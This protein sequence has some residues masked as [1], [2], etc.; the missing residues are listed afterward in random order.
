MIDKN[1]QIQLIAV[2]S[3]SSTLSL[4]SQLQTDDFIAIWIP[5]YS[6]QIKANN[7]TESH[8]YLTHSV[9]WGQQLFQMKLQNEKN[10]ATVI[11]NQR[12][13]KKTKGF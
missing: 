3:K 8:Q 1:D 6:N 10:G 7:I 9:N 13:I 4:N 11:L 5:V 2:A 12:A